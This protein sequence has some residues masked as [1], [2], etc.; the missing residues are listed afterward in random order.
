MLYL[1]FVLTFLAGILFYGMTP[2]DDKLEW[3]THQ[4]EGMVAPFLNQHQA[5]R[6]YL[7]AWLGAGD[8]TIQGNGSFLNED[9][10]EMMPNSMVPSI[11]PGNNGNPGKPGDSCSSSR[12][13]SRVICLEKCEI[14]TCGKGTTRTIAFAQEPTSGWAKTC[15]VLTYGGGSA[16]AERPDWWPDEQHPIRRNERWRRAIARRIRGSHNCGVLKKEGSNWC[17]DNGQRIYKNE[18]Q[19]DRVCANQVPNALIN[20]LIGSN[21]YD[22][23][24]SLEDMLFCYS[25]FKQGVKPGHYAKVP[26]YFYDGLSNAGIGEHSTQKNWR[27]LADNSTKA[28]GGA[29]SFSADKPYLKV[30]E[31]F[32]TGISL[33]SS[34]TLTILAELTLDTPAFD[35]FSI[36]AAGAAVSEKI[37]TAYETEDIV[38]GETRIRTYLCWGDDGSACASITPKNKLLPPNHNAVQ[39]NVVSWTFTWDGAKMTVYENAVKLSTYSIPSASSQNPTGK[40]LCMGMATNGDAHIYGIRYY[41]GVLDDKKI[42]KNFKIDQKRFGIADVSNGLTY[43]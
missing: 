3:D 30:V 38:D 43:M 11:C 21:G 6:D 20:A 25:A 1:L 27:N 9:F 14:D 18:H 26:D 16:L 13:V 8:S 39:N 22:S 33:G 31:E 17:I 4:S 15:Y 40:S 29:N 23:D 2:R 5:A 7:F 37:F 32:D 36:K 41:G 12:F 19:E 28:I 24:G 35:L 34:F 42:Q 10:E